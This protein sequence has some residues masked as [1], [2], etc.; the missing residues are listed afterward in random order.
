MLDDERRDVQ[1]LCEKLMV[2]CQQTIADFGS[3]RRQT[4]SYKLEDLQASLFLALVATRCL[5]RHV[6]SLMEELAD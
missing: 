3:A 5:V 6:E 1:K 2:Q 4:V